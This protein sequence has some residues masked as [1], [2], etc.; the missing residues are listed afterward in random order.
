MSAD[1]AAIGRGTDVAACVRPQPGAPTRPE[2]LLYG[3]VVMASAA[4]V[5]TGALLKPDPRGHGTHEQVGL[6]PCP[7]LRLTGFPCATCG[8]TTAL[9]QMARFRW[10]DALGTHPFACL[11]FAGASLVLLRAIPC[12]AV[13]RCDGLVFRSLGSGWCWAAC[14]AVYLGSWAYKA[15]AVVLTR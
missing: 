5:L 9:A 15:L 4:L 10:V 1:P 13:G 3:A 7:L 8:F 14:A 2:R 12:L 6:P 11:A